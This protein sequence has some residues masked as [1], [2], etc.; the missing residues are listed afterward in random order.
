MK[1]ADVNLKKTPY[2]NRNYKIVCRVVDFLPQKLEQFCVRKIRQPK[3]THSILG[4]NGQTMHFYSDGSSKPAFGGG[5]DE[6]QGDDDDDDNQEWEFKF[7]LLVEGKDGAVIRL[8]VND[9]SA[10]FLL[11][12]DATE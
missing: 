1:P 12:M 4:S 10:Q 8:M 9:K 3:R 2:V 11:K 5:E 6:D 7:A